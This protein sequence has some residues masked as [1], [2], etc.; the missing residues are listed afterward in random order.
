MSRESARAVLLRSGLLSIVCLGL[1]EV[2]RSQEAREIGTVQV[3]LSSHDLSQRLFIQPNL[4]LLPGKSG[5]IRINPCTTYQSILGLGSS[6]EHSTCYNIS[7]L[8]SDRQEAVI[9]SIV[10]PV[11]GIGMNLMRICIGSP[12]FTASPWYTYDDMPPGETDPKLERFSV[13]K[14][15]EYVLPVLKMALAK[16]PD[17]L[18]V[19]SAWS[20][21][22][23]MKTNDE[24][25]GGSI[26]RKHF[27]AYGEY[28]ARFVKAY[29]AEGIPI[30]AVTPQNEPDCKNP[31]YPTCHW[32]GKEQR[33]FIR[34]HLGPVFKAQG[35]LA[36]IWCWD[37]NFN[38]LSFPRA[39]LNDPQCASYVEGTAFHHYGGK[40]EAM[41]TLHREFPQKDI[42]FTEGST[43]GMGGAVRIIRYLRNWARGYNAWVTII[44]HKRHPNPGPHMCGATCIVLNADT[45][46]TEYRFDYYM[47]GQFMKFI[48]R[49]AVRVES[50]EPDK[51]L[52]NVAFLNPSGELVLVV[53]NLSGGAREF[54]VA[55]MGSVFHARLGGKSI[56]T[57]R[58]NPSPDQ[59]AAHL[60]QAS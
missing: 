17:L 54:S 36:G 15:R 20:P 5:D 55:C 47:Y 26:S 8:P 35:I 37:H 4:R 31:K 25:G 19:A 22:A 12:D 27:A 7:K 2:A 21:P 33:D 48:Q 41:T 39:I 49:G 34:D 42:F 58:W 38:L 1:L 14:D 13:E 29:E 46:K 57:Y 16:N 3:V 50:T 52:P 53:A 40:A 60:D 43:F 10:D 28:L 6:L 11:K 23:W 24:I 9:Q 18:F 45:L 44:D 59:A 56:A 51:S 30:R 32:T